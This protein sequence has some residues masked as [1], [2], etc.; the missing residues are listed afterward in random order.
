VPAALAAQRVNPTMPAPPAVSVAARLDRLPASRYLR[1]LIVLLSLG[2]CFEFYDLFFSAYIAPALYRS[3][4]FTPTTTG[5]LDI[6]GFAGFI[7]SLFAGLLVGTLF[8]ARISDRFGRR[9]IFSFSLLWYSVC[10]FIMAFQSTA[11]AID[12]WRFFAGVGVGVELVTIG[13]YLSELVPPENRGRAFAFNQFISFLAVPLA[14]LVSWLLVPLRI[15][16][17]D[18]WRWVALLGASGAIFVWFIRRALPESP[19]CS[20]N[21]AKSKRPTA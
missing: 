6:R 14:A 1:R 18:G 4:I 7:A 2:G 11:A 8:F 20:S 16:G 19:R 13:A 9:A 3:G 5:F 21:K 15:W 17:I 10:T 12:L